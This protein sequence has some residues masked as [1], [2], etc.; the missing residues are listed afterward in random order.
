M[1]AVIGDNIVRLFGSERWACVSSLVTINIQPLLASWDSKAHPNQLA[2]QNYLSVIKEQV[3]TIANIEEPLYLRVHSLVTPSQMTVG[4]DLENYLTPL[5]RSLNDLPIVFARATKDPV[6]ASFVEIGIAEATSKDLD[7]DWRQFSGVV[8]NLSA[9]KRIWKEELRSQLIKAACT[10]APPGHMR[11]GL[12]INCS[13]RRSWYNLWKPVGDSFGP[14][15]GE[16][17][18]NPFHPADDRI[19]DLELHLSHD[20]SLGW[21]VAIEAWWKNKEVETE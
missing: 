5:A 7:Q 15:L 21:D 11:M 3:L 18:S 6:T 16:P 13:P 19:V 8:R 17:N 10:K 14:V 1:E 4:H 12:S 9:D 20:E 2:L